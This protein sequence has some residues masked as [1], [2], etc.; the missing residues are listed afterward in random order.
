[1]LRTFLT[2]A[3]LATTLMTVSACAKH[4][5]AANA[6]IINETVPNDPAAADANTTAPD[7]FDNGIAAANDAAPLNAA[8]AAGNAQ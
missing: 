2:A 3:T 5:D 8:D 7:A 6:V 1:M 4:D